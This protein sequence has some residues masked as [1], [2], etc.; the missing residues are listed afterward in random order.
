M[1]ADAESA[2]FSCNRQEF[3]PQT[4][5]LAHASV[6]QDIGNLQIPST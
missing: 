4:A 1:P 2:L 3:L 5:C 6:I